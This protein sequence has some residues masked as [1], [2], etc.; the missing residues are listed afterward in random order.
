VVERRRYLGL[1][2]G[3]KKL[4]CS[5]ILRPSDIL[6]KYFLIY[7]LIEHA[8]TQNLKYSYTPMENNT[9]RLIG[10]ESSTTRTRVIKSL[11]DFHLNL[12]NIVGYAKLLA[13]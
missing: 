4:P 11:R 7:V 5:H 1:T 9:N 10:S 8:I 2:I 6:T 12:N 13:T 3:I